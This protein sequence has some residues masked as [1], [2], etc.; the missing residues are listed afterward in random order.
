LE[1]TLID[2]WDGLVDSIDFFP[3]GVYTDHLMALLSEDGTCHETYV[4]RSD[5]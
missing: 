2:R 5:D 1:T 4:S 3:V